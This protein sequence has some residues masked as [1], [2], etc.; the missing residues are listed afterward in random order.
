M[1]QRMGEESSGAGI[2]LAFVFGTI[3]LRAVFSFWLLVFS[4]ATGGVSELWCLNCD[5]WDLGDGL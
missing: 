1:W 5:L 3:C 2:Q 4:R